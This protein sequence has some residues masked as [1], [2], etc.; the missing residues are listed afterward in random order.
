V[1]LQTFSNAADPASFSYIDVDSKLLNGYQ[2]NCWHLPN[3]VSQSNRHLLGHV[4]VARKWKRDLLPMFEV[5]E[6]EM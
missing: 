4:S 3:I 1:Q 2:I 5:V 6:Y